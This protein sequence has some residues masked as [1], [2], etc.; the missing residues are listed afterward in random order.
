MDE[1]RKG[2]QIPTKSVILPYAET[3]GQAAIDLYNSTGR[4]AQ[5]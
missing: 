4:T 5:Q 2:R 1:L 3:H